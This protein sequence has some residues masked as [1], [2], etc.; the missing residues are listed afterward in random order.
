M[1]SHFFK[2]FAARFF[3]IFYLIVFFSGFDSANSSA[4]FLDNFDGS[5]IQLD[6]D[7]NDGWAFFTGDGSATMDFRQ[8]NDY[9]SIFVDA[10]KDQHGIWWALIRRCISNNMDLNLLTKPEHEFRIETRIRVSHAPRRV[11]L[12]LNT[13]RT[14]DFHSH[15]M[16]FDIPDTA[17]WHT[18]S[19]TTDHFD[20]RSGDSVYGQLALMDWGLEKYRVDVDYFKVDIVRVDTIGPDKGIQVPYRPPIPDV[21]TFNQQVVVTQDCIIDL[22]YPDINFNDWSV[23]EDEERINLITISGTQII[24]L[25]WDFKKM[26]GKQAIGSGLL[27]LTTFSA[28]HSADHKKDFG[29]LRVCEIVGGDKSWDQKK[30]TLTSFCHGQPLMKVINSQMIIDIDVSEKQGDKTFITISNP[31]LQRLIDGTTLG[32]AIR[33][34]GAISASFY[35]TEYNGGSRGARL[36]LNISTNSN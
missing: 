31:V 33:P 9:A 17:N 35:S 27:E 19:L 22:Q 18:I 11:N 36:F 2:I 20:A 6:P 1:N 28:Q 30:V 25:R 24:I 21:R 23:V 26:L 5:S 29:M 13:Q 14:I 3:L 16:E 32:I 8:I 12:H 10:G 4:Q 7:A 34:L 15:L